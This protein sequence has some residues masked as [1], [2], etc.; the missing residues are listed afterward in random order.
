[1]KALLCAIL[2]AAPLSGAL[3]ESLPAIDALTPSSSFAA[4]VRP[5]VPVDIHRQAMR[6]LWA[7]N[8]S[9]A[10][11]DPMDMDAPQGAAVAAPA[12]AVVIA[13][14]AGTQPVAVLAP[15]ERLTR[16]SDYTA[17]L[18]DGVPL[19]LHQTAMRR[20]WATHPEF[21]VYSNDDMHSADYVDATAGQPQTRADAGG[22]I[23][24][25]SAD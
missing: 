22:T 1:M 8:P 5:D 4:F 15:A 7:L 16:H 13:S 17:Y 23:T 25:V 12:T 21:A 6:R 2:V 9:L 3:A 19:S 14:P 10:G 18:S 11:P 20:L 24:L